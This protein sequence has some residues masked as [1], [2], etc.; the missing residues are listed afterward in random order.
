MRRRPPDSMSTRRSV[1]PASSEFSMSSFTTEAGR[2]TTSPA[3]ILFATASERTR[4]RPINLS[5]LDGDSPFDKK[6]AGGLRERGE[7]AS[8]RDSLIGEVRLCRVEGRLGVEHEEERSG[9][10]IELLLFRVET[11]LRQIEC[12]TCELYRRLAALD[13][14]QRV[15]DVQ[16]RLLLRRSH[17]KQI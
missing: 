7:I 2:S 14:G 13:L 15:N 1:A 12:D 6:G 11:L 3:A 5:L 17:A 4:M 9:A 8:V 16:A 10:E